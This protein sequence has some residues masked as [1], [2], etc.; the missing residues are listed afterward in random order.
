[1]SLAVRSTFYLA[2]SQNMINLTKLQNTC[3]VRY[4]LIPETLKCDGKNSI[5]IMVKK[6]N[7]LRIL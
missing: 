3:P 6:F 7:Q 5:F 1:M 4:I 2:N